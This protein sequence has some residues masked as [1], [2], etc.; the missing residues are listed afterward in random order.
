VAAATEKGTR[1][2]T[3]HMIVEEA[4]GVGEPEIARF[5]LKVATYCTIFES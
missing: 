1:S 3:E 2:R 5:A 4:L